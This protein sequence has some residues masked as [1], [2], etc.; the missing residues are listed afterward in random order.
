MCPATRSSN[1]TRH[2]CGY[3][4][5]H[6]MGMGVQVKAACMTEIVGFAPMR[7]DS[8]APKYRQSSGREVAKYLSK[9]QDYQSSVPECRRRVRQAE[10]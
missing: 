8:A 4:H 5:R 2:G 7:A 3:G 6:R 1:G 10:E 9:V